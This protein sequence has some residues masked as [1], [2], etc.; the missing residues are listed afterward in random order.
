MTVC[1]SVSVL[2]N[3]KH[4]LL[5]V[6]NSSITNKKQSLLKADYFASTGQNELQF[7]EIN[8]KLKGEDFTLKSEEHD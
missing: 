8:I 1:R 4:N 5:R 2:Y 3:K 7:I 6:V